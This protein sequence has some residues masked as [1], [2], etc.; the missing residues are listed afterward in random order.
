MR[1]IKETFSYKWFDEVWN[2]SNVEAIDKLMWQDVKAYG[3]SPENKAIDGN[4]FKSF[5]HDFTSQY[6]DIHVEVQDVVSQD[7]IESARCWVTLTNKETGE[8][9]AFAGICMAKF[10]EGKIIEAWNC[11]D[12]LGMNAQLGLG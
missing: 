1:A 8:K 4:D 11:Y 6:K 2:K 5:Y 7:D 12:F 10:K 3:L 9:A